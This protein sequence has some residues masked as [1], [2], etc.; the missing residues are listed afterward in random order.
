MSHSTSP[1]TV[2]LYLLAALGL[3]IPWYYNIAFLLHGGSFAPGPFAS[4]ITANLLTTGITWD[5][6]LAAAAFSVWVT[7]DASASGVR[8]PWF[9]IAL[10]FCIGLAFALPLYLARRRTPA[11]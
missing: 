4:A 5:V 11:A 10:C 2:L 9:Y 6:Y 1:R 8:R 3:A 7:G